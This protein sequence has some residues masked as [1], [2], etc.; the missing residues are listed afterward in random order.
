VLE[1]NPD[2]GD[3]GLLVVGQFIVQAYD[4]L[5][6]ADFRAR[7]LLYTCTISQLKLIA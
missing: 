1:G 3:E 4:R 7:S 5:E 2:D 6:V